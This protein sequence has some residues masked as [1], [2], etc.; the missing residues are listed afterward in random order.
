M[1]RFL[2]L[3][4]F[5]CVALSSQA[6][7]IRRH[8]GQ[9]RY[10]D[11][12]VLTKEEQQLLLSDIEGHDY[13]APWNTARRLRGTGL[14]LTIGGG[15]AMGVGAMG[16][17]IGAVTS[18]LGAVIGGT[19]GSMGGQEGAQEG[20]SAGA[21]A[22]TPLITAGLIVGAVGVVATATGIPMLVVNTRRM[23]KIVNTYNNSLNPEEPQIQASI[24]FGFTPHGIG[25]S[26]QF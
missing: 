8:G 17:T 18:A 5:L 4:C 20:A 7:Y 14:G 19:V 21:K 2:L 25:L 9:L 26:Y 11:G 22:G 13:N 16:V 24:N 1:K 3:I 12:Q 23:N 10:Q 15:V 6:Q